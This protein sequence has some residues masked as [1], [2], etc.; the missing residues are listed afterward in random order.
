MSDT[1][2][3]GGSDPVLLQII[4]GLTEIKTGLEQH[5]K[6]LASIQQ[7]IRNFDRTLVG[8]TKD[9]EQ[10][11]KDIE[12]RTHQEETAR[13]HQDIISLADAVEKKASN[14]IVWWIMGIIASIFLAGVSGFVKLIFLP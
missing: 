12:K 7:D 8:L 11:K 1:G 4:G 9:M 5:G 3:P 10:A 14:R 13:L 6:Q 2:K